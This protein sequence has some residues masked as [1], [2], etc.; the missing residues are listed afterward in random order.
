MKNVSITCKKNVASS[1]V[2]S[3]FWWWRCFRRSLQALKNVPRAPKWYITLR[4]R[5]PVWTPQ[6]INSGFFNIHI[7]PELTSSGSYYH[8]H[9][10]ML[11]LRIKQL[12]FILAKALRYSLC[13]RFEKLTSKENALHREKSCNTILCYLDACDIQ[14]CVLSV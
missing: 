9:K 5:G 14:L 8:L 1:P 10:H 7:L 6:K 3:Q 2:S 11:C 13:K 4:T 12:I